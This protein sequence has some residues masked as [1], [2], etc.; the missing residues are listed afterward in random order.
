MTPGHRWRPG[1]WLPI[2]AYVGLVLGISAFTV[3]STPFAISD[4]AAHVLE[5]AG[6]G[7]LTTRALM[8]QFSHVPRGPLVLGGAMFAAACGAMDEWVQS[9]APLRTS[10]LHDFAA[11]VVGAVLG[12]LITL[13][14][15]RWRRGTDG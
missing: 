1:L 13:A 12:A 11:D 4:K 15:F 10:D 8:L 9:Y 6:L 5:F 2:P 3:P 14:F 7:A